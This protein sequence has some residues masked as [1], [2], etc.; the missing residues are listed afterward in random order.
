VLII[1]LLFLGGCATVTPVSEPAKTAVISSTPV[2]P[3]ASRE[4]ERRSEDYVVIIANPSDTYETLAASYLGDARLA[5]II[6]EFNNK[7]IVPGK[8]VAIPLKPVNPGGLYADG[9][10]TVQ[11][12]CYHQFSSKKSSSKITVPEE[13][14]DR[15]MAYLKNN[16]YTVIS[17]KQLTE[18]INYQRRP[19]PKSVIITID[20]GWKTVKTI[21]YPILKKYGFTAALFVYTDLIKAKQSSVALSWDDL[22]EMVDSGVIEI[23]SHT[24]S[25]SDLTKLS[26]DRLQRELRDSQRLIK[27]KLGVTPTFLAYPY[28]NFNDTVVEAMQ[29]NGYKAGFTV[30]RGATAFFH[31]SYSL[32]RSMV[33]NSDKLDDFARLL[34]TFR[35]EKL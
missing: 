32:N 30:I 7:P 19:P 24:A 33:F 15:Q 6:A 29:K 20:D 10:Q 16:G 21:A 23:E 27:S 3:Q 4:R 28:G 34:V 35:R 25:H 13:T 18:F 2:Q 5:Y 11:V 17:L 14:F 9:Y 12:L 26:A 1:L 22:K 31:N 8:D